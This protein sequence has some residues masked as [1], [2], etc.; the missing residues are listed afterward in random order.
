MVTV[1][2]ELEFSLKRKQLYAYRWYY[3]FFADSFVNVKT[4]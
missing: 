2:Q 3:K 1:K 4:F